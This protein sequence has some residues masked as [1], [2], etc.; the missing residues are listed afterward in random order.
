M[1]G[2]FPE[3]M[4]RRKFLSMLG[5]AGA[6]VAL[7]LPALPRPET[8]REYYR[9]KKEEAGPGGWVSYKYRYTVTLAPDT[10][11]RLRFA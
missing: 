11:T 3:F 4:Q 6:V 9:R 1:T 5:M 10:A 2:G 7:S 8:D